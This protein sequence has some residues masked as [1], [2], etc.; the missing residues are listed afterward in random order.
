MRQRRRT[1]GRYPADE[2]T[3]RCVGCGIAF[4]TF[5]LF[6]PEDGVTILEPPGAGAGNWVGAPSVL[7][8]S[9]RVLLAYRRRRPRGEARDRGY[10]ACIAESADGVHFTD[11]W[12][13]EKEQL[14]STSMERFCLHRDPGGR[15]L[16]YL[17]YEHPEDGR[18]RIDVL[19][20]SRPEDFD[21]GSRVTVLTPSGTGTAAVKDPYVVRV[22]PAYYMFVS[23]FLTDAGPAPTSLAVSSDGLEFRWAGTVFDVGTGWDRYQARLSGIVRAGGAFVGFYDGAADPSEDTE[24]RLGLAFSSDLATWERVSVDEPWLLSPHAT[25][26]RYLDAIELEGEWWLY[27]EYARADGAHELR[28]SRVPVVV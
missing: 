27:Y 9:E 13:V 11:V 7:Y 5:P 6:D 12:S 14:E 8:D 20:A 21:A 19:E 26:I 23:T 24:E 18:W 15:Y 22:G 10:E 4:D 25:S 28:L 2:R 17:S 3:N 1:P 16:L